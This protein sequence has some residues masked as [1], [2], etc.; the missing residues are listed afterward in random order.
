MMVALI[1]LAALLLI[2]TYLGFLAFSIVFE[3]RDGVHLEFVEAQHWGA[4]IGAIAGLGI[5]LLWRRIS[6]SSSNL[7]H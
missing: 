4:V 6:K 1:R 3:Q 5:E 2:G 7:T